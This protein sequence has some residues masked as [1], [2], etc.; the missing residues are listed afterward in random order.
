MSATR[1]AFARSVL[2]AGLAP[3][4]AA[5]ARAASA[6]GASARES[7]PK[8]FLWGCATASYQVEGAVKEDGRGPSVWDVFSHKPGS[9]Q[10]GDTGDVAA[11][12]YHRYKEDVQ[13]LKWL[14]AKAYRF[15]V[16]WPRIFPQG[17]GQPNEKG[18]AY[19]DRLVDELLAQG[20]EPWVTL[21][22]W[23]LPQALEDKAGG[24]E[25]RDT[26]KQFADYAA[27][28]TRRLSDRVT[29]YFT[30][31]EVV[32]FI[33]L[34]YGQ[35]NHAP[36]K[37]LPA[38]RLNQARHHGLLAHGLALQ[39][40]R[41]NA[42]KPVS[43]GVAENPSLCTPILDAPDHIAA[44]RTA[45]REI[46][47]PILT[48]MLEGRYTDSFLSAAGKDAPRF[49]AEEMKLIGGKLDFV[50]LNCYTPV[51]IQASGGPQGFERV[52]HAASH[53]T[54]NVDWI[55]LDPRILYWTPRFVN[56]LWM[57]AAIYITENG[58]PSADSIAPD[59]KIY[60]TDRVMYLRH[61]LSQLRRAI[62]D[63]VPLRGYFYWSLLDNFEWAYGYTQRFGLYHVDF[64]TQKRTGKLSASFFRDVIRQN[65]VA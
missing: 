30:T 24:W 51:Y 25:S 5:T 20:I 50:G 64:K 18:M 32:C 65:S 34:S 48:A 42:R 7:F 21:Y 19:Y 45:M 14:G 44:A 4:L 43:V 33:D 61:H 41:A 15:S 12:S 49:T 6:P 40:V 11:D 9:V 31:N 35:G 29:N 38:G 39:A 28:V 54:M 55:H 17:T 63:G 1:R 8:P 10:N 60:D 57:P 59:G 52:P 27:H 22:H 2:G 37:R 62:D 23:D 56:E 13:L 26:A 36:G 46:N 3:A 47:A 53:P 58:C 16:A